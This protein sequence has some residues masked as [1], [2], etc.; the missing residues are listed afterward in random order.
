MSAR[1]ASGYPRSIAVLVSV[2]ILVGAAL[3]APAAAMAVDPP[4]A[5]DPI[6]PQIVTQAADQDWSDYHPIPGSPYA[7][8]SIEP[9][10]TR[11]DVA[12]VL[13]DF[14]GT[15]FAVTQD[16]GSTV[17]GNPGPLA[18][19]LPRTSVGAFYRDWL[20]TPSAQNQF[21]G[22]NRYWMEDS[23][24]RYG[25]NLQSYGPYELIGTQDDYF[26]ND[27]SGSSNA[28]C[29]TQARTPTGSAQLNVTDVL[30][31]QSTTSTSF[32]VG[33]ILRG[34]VTGQTGTFNRVVTEVPDATH[35]RTGAASSMAAASAVGATNI[36]YTATG[37]LQG[38]AAGHTLWI[39]MGERLEVRTH[40]DRRHQRLGRH[41]AHF[42][43]SIDLR[44]HKRQ[45]PAR[46]DYVADQLRARQRIHLQLRSQLP[47]RHRDRLGRLRFCNRT[48]QLRQ[49]LPRVGR[50]GRERDVAG[51]R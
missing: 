10:N 32:T 24:G 18:H 33:K 51:I 38:L 49:Q 25:V 28:T 48:R 50:S 23:Y 22:M 16:E 37:G 40:R 9:T 8:N 26:I 1:V 43:R 44:S 42:G 46:H 41:G 3:V 19:N 11:W 14:P 2:L 35:I 6:D 15:P 39:G 7:D 30:L 45:L 5:L 4:P 17:F 13:A 47:N 12:L 29:N 21:Q 36:K 34:I 31:G 27:I 20:N